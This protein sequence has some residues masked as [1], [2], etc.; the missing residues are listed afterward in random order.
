ML[1]SILLLSL[2]STSLE[3]ASSSLTAATT[4]SSLLRGGPISDGNDDHDTTRGEWV[5]GGTGTEDDDDG[6]R[7]FIDVHIPCYVSFCIYMYFSCL[8]QYMVCGLFVHKEYENIRDEKRSTFRFFVCTQLIFVI[9]LLHNT[10]LCHL[11]LSVCI[12]SMHVC[13]VHKA[14]RFAR[15]NIGSRRATRIHI[16]PYT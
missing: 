9:C 5:T 1:R 10:I 12:P 3:K 13:L 16:P 11:S 7:F 6:T 8:L 15:K 2:L 14:A 4:S